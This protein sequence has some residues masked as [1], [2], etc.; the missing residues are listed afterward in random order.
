MSCTKFIYAPS[1]S[2]EYFSESCTRS[3]ERESLR[4]DTDLIHLFCENQEFLDYITEKTAFRLTDRLKQLYQRI[5]NSLRHFSRAIREKI[6]AEVR[7]KQMKTTI[8][9]LHAKAEEGK[10]NGED[11]IE[12]VDV[13][14]IEK[15][16]R[17]YYKKL[18]D[19]AKKICTKRYTHLSYLDDDL[20]EFDYWYEKAED[21]VNYAAE[22][23]IDVPINKAIRFAED[24]MTGKRDMV[25]FIDNSIR[26]FEEMARKVEKMYDARDVKG[27]DVL[28]KH[29]GVLQKVSTKLGTFVSKTC[30][31]G[32]AKAVASIVLVC[33]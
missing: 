22:T 7:T 18:S 9:K 5:I 30:G 15:A 32:I 4:S 17:T 13:W 24:N 16:C 21:D 12:M 8:R 31:K 29:I 6:D 19:L 1:Q 33:A 10:K 28:Q 26:D 14:G 3:I 2:I 27:A 25:S 11:T 23:K 20:S